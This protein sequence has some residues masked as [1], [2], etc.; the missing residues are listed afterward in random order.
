MIGRDVGQTIIDLYVHMLRSLSLSCLAKSVYNRS[1]TENV[2]RI[3]KRKHGSNDSTRPA[4]RLFCFL[5]PLLV[6]KKKK[7]KKLMVVVVVG[8]V[9]KFDW[10]TIGSSSTF[11]SPLSSRPSSQLLVVIQT[12]R[13]YLMVWERK[14]RGANQSCVVFHSKRFKFRSSFN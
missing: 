9:E 14:K 2:Y 5:F 13:L 3:E 4:V 1:E 10:P 8:S 11:T 12:L 7:W 6:P